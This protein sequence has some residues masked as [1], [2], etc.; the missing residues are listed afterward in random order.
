LFQQ[1]Q[2][3]RTAMPTID[4]RTDAALDA[5]AEANLVTHMGWVQQRTAGMQLLADERLTLIDSGLPCDSFNFVCRARLTPASLRERIVWA[6]RHFATARRPYSWWVGPADR[7]RDLGRAL[8]DAGF[9]ASESE[10]AMAADL[11]ALQPA[12]LAPDGLHI[13]RVATQRQLRD[14]AAINAANWSPPDA[15]VLRFY[16]LAAPLLLAPGCPMWLY[17]GSVDGQP[18]STAELT[19][20]GGVAGLYNIATLEAHRRKGYGSALTLRPLL[21]ARAQ[22]Y[23]TAVLQASADGQ[24][25]YARIGFR[26]VGEYTEYAPTDSGGDGAR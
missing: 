3:E 8:L 12:D 1:V 20:G 21:D 15:A 6:A 19:V 2:Q 26:A 4:G 14:F 22:G 18:V 5:A 9:R 23:R 25:V 11:D 10:L 17:L 16:E 24:G 7:P 13:E